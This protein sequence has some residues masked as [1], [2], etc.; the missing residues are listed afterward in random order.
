MRYEILSEIFLRD[1]GFEG[2]GDEGRVNLT[3]QYGLGSFLGLEL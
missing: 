3:T 2:I 1:F